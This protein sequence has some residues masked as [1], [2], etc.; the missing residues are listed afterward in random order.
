MTQKWPPLSEYF[1]ESH[2]QVQ[3]S[4]VIDGILLLCIYSEREALP[5]VVHSNAHKSPYEMENL[6]EYSTRVRVSK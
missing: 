5:H 3:V 6:E 2:S 1:F 4:D